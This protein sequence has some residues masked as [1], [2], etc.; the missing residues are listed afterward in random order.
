[1]RF[2]FADR[3][4]AN[5]ASRFFD[6]TTIQGDNAE[7]GLIERQTSNATSEKIEKE[8]LAEDRQEVS[9][10]L[11]ALGIKYVVLAKEAD[12]KDYGWLDS[13]PGLG[14]VSDTATL[15]VYEVK[16]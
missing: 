11:K 14:L 13:Q 2:G 16:P 12:Y 5:P 7:I 1:M 4:I 10:K 8:I 9:K 15:K 3:L 6:R